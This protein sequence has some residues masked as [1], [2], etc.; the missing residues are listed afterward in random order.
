MN[1]WKFD[2]ASNDYT[3]FRYLDSAD[4]AAKTFM[5]DGTPKNWPVP[6]KCRPFVET[7]KKKKQLPLADLSYI[8]PGSILLNSKA[9]QALKDFLLPFGQLL[10]VECINEGGLLGDKVSEIYYFY[11]ITNLIP[12]VDY[13]NS[14]KIGTGVYKPA[15]FPDQVP[16]D[17]QIFKDPITKRG[18]IYLTDLAKESFVKLIAAAQLNGG[19]LDQL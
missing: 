7:Q 9:Y 19:T 12:C 14:E 3:P 1:I 18:H 6:P 2:S 17:L 10:A 8:S 5:T 11:N 4:M 13:E 16:Q 15:F